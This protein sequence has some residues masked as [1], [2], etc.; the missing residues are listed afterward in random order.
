MGGFHIS[1]RQ[2]HGEQGLVGDD[3]GVGVFGGST[4]VPSTILPPAYDDLARLGFESACVAQ[5]EVGRECAEVSEA[6][7]ITLSERNTDKS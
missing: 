1:A 2:A 6:R 7:A 5:M 3:F 4:L